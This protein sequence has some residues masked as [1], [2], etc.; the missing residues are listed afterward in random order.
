[1]E[2]RT[3]VILIAAVAIIGTLAAC[4]IISY[5][6]NTVAAQNNADF[7]LF[8]SWMTQYNSIFEGHELNYRF[9]VFQSNLNVIR[10]HNANPDK[11]FEMGPNQFTALTPE[12]FSS[13][14]FGYDA[15]AVKDIPI[16]VLPTSNLPSSVNWTAAG[17]V[18]DVKNQGDCGSCWSFST[19]GSMEGLNA[20]KNDQLV[21][22][23]EA[24]LMDC[25]WFYGNKACDGGSMVAA[26][27][28]SAKRGL[29]ND[30]VYPYTGKTSILCKYKEDEVQ[31]KNSGHTMVTP[32]SVEQLMAATVQQPISIAVEANQASWQNYKSGVITSGCGQ[33]L[34]HGVLVVG[35]GETEKNVSYWLVKNSWGVTWGMEGYLMIEKSGANIC[36]VLSQPV[37]PTV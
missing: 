18:T 2:S 31:F 1:M 29:M 10:T 32:N 6:Q 27:E 5:D 7:E 35:Y 21:S 36:G 37:Y 17:A 8:Q 34:D 12:E 16:T 25:S 24:Q 23:S 33:Q 3:Q 26:L 15:N 13:R 14:F 9:T 4:A 19:C 28:Y 22:L 20:I 11:T 30:T